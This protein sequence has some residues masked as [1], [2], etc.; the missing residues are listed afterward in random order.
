MRFLLTTFMLMVACIAV[1]ACSKKLNTH[2]YS[3]TVYFGIGQGISEID[4]KNRDV[5]TIFIK[6]PLSITSLSEIDHQH[7]LINAIQFGPMQSNNSHQ[8]AERH[9]RGYSPRDQAFVFNLITGTITPI[10]TDAKG[11]DDA[12]YLRK[13]DAIIFLGEKKES[14]QGGMYWIRKSDP[15][16]WHLIDTNAGGE[17]PPVIVSDDAVVYRDRDGRV[18]MFDLENNQISVLNLSDC[19][20]VLWRSVTQQLVCINA[21]A[22]NT[23]YFYLIS[24]DGKG[25]QRLPIRYGP[26]V[27]IRHYDLML[28]SSVSGSFSWRYMRP[29]ERMD[30]WSYNFKSG[31]VEKFLAGYGAVIGGAYFE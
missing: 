1:T 15:N 26:F 29:D 2:Q 22:S 31:E 24:L 16:S 8:T 25:R 10:F 6:Q 20:P 13:H 21:Y 14:T 7:L 9:P 18:K 12:V 23:S 28:L 3:G 4:M 19:Y 27:Y 11:I 5:H 30:M 17:Y